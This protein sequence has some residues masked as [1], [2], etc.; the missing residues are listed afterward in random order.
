MEYKDYPFITGVFFLKGHDLL[1]MF[2]SG[3]E[4]IVDMSDS[5]EVPAALKY[6]PPS[7]FKKFSF[8]KDS[9]WWGDEDWIV[10]HDSLYNMSTPVT[11][12]ASSSFLS[13]GVV[14]HRKEPFEGWI[15]INGN[16]GTTGHKEPHAHVEYEGKKFLFALCGGLLVPEPTVSKSVI[17]MLDEW[18][19]KNKK[20]CVEEWNRWNPTLLADPVTGRRT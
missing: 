4:R 14:D 9:I 19:Q 18:V 5:F 20:I 3:E 11:Q 7:E 1:V 10:G 6:A 13:M 17:D 8:N 12:F 15:R 16:E 2:D